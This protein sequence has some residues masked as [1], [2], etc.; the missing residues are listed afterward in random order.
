MG[1]KLHK[2]S[3]LGT[4]FAAIALMW[5]FAASASADSV[6]CEM[7]GNIKVSPG[8]TESP[9][10]QNIQIKGSLS[11]CAGTE[12]KVMSASYNAHLKT[13]EAVSCATLKGTGSPSAAE[14]TILLKWGGEEGLS[15]ATFSMPLT[16]MSVGIGG[17][18]NK[19]PFNGDT[20]SGSVTQKYEACGGS[21][22][23]GHGH[24]KGK[25]V[26]RGTLTGTITIS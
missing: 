5:A 7:S 9:K 8:L 22:G 2:L 10:V 18:V 3:V 12:T 26:K 21:P 24:G 13:A 25:K 16:E 20:I 11:K 23:H 14:S 1:R 6:T 17:M 4:L 19:G 15:E